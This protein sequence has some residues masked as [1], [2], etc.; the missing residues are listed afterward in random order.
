MMK[1][2]A[3]FGA[4][5]VLALATGAATAEDWHRHFEYDRGPHRFGPRCE[6]GIRA[7]GESPLLAFGGG[8]G[9]RKAEARA[10]RDWQEEAVHLF[11]PRFGDWNLAAD[12]NVHCDVNGLNFVCVARGNPCRP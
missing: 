9:A 7:H 11:G 8:G 12:R 10:I 2:A 1:W 6:Y 5:T 4:V 3:A